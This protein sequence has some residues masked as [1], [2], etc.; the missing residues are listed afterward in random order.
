MSETSGSLLLRA[1]V[2][3]ADQ[4]AAAHQLRAREGG[5]FGECLVRTGAI[6]EDKLVEFYHRRLMIPRLA[7]GKLDHIP[8]RVI[9]LVSAD[10]AAEFRVIPVEIDGE[11]TITLAMADP[12]DNHAVDEVAFFADRFVVRAVA[13]ES[14][15]RRAIERY[16]GV[17]FTG[18]AEEPARAPD[19]SPPPPAKKELFK[20]PTKEQL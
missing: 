4:I 2:L 1:G 17:V 7:E 18:A 13:S 9:A 15:V 8:V 20:K 16:Y 10:M 12:S 14:S 3:R 5:S 6:S 19:P 11:G